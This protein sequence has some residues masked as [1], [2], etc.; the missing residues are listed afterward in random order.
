MECKMR[1][2]QERRENRARYRREARWRINLATNLDRHVETFLGRPFLCGDPCYH[3]SSIQIRATRG[4]GRRIR[5]DICAVSGLF[6]TAIK[7][8]SGARCNYADTRVIN[9]SGTAS[10]STSGCSTS[11]F[12][13]FS[14]CWF[15]FGCLQIPT[16]S[17]L[18]CGVSE[19][20]LSCDQHPLAVYSL[21]RNKHKGPQFLDQSR[22]QSHRN[23]ISK[24]YRRPYQS[25]T[26]VIPRTPDNPPTKCVS[27][28]KAR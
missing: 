8:K 6:K 13:T 7:N 16:S 21:L 4:G 23:I 9:G 26:N 12:D 10:C 1:S 2:E 3:V 28:R 18:P 22:N 27:G 24:P 17:F 19:E 14:T 25:N 5:A 20:I 11:F 15:Q